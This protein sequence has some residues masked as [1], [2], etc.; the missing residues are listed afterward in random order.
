ML[1]MALKQTETIQFCDKMIV[2]QV[3][4]HSVPLASAPWR[5]V[6]FE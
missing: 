4:A 6:L 1:K 5:Q 3:I 2:F